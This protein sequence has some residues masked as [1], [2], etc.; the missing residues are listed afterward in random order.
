MT[1]PHTALRV[2]PMGDGEHAAVGDL[3]VRAYLEAEG[4][5]AA[6]GYADE[7]RDAAGHAAVADV[8]VAE[9]ADGALLGAVTFLAS[10][11]NPLAEHDDAEAASVRFLAVEPGARRAGVARALMAACLERAG[12]AG[13]PRMRLHVIDTN[14]GAHRLYRALGFVRDAATDIEPLPGARLQGY[15]RDLGPP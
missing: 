7:L 14:A 6:G 10:G 4:T 15:V 11:D 2:R 8:L 12:A 3:T 13:A 1:A 5:Y 9:D